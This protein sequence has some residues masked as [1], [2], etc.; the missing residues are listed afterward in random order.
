MLQ[1]ITLEPYTTF[2]VGTIIGAVAMGAVA[3][4]EK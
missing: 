4:W 2:L 3:F 1:Y